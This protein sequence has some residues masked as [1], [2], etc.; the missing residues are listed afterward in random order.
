MKLRMLA[1]SAI[2]LAT[3][4]STAPAYAQGAMQIRVDDFI[5]M[6]D[7]NHD[8]MVTRQE[9]VNA[10]GQMYDKS[11]AKMANDSMMVKNHMMTK[12]GVRAL[13]SN[14]YIGGN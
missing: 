13:L 1:A 7:Q 4:I 5:K 12:G 2:T 3:L 10:M 8:G 11:M 14:L 6:A 9:F